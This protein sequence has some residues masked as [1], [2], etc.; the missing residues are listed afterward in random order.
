MRT[1]LQALFCFTFCFLYLSIS[2]IKA[3]DRTNCYRLTVE[4]IPDILDSINLHYGTFGLIS[5]HEIED[6]LQ[7]QLN[8]YPI[9]VEAV[10]AP[11]PDIMGFSSITIDF[12]WEHTNAPLLDF[13]RI[14]VLNLQESLEPLH[15]Q[16]TPDN[17][18]SVGIRPTLFE[19]LQLFSF[20]SISNAQ[21][22]QLHI[23]IID[24]DATIRC[25]NGG[26][27]E[28]GENIP[29]GPTGN[30]QRRRLSQN[31]SLQTIQTNLFPNP[32][33]G[34]LTNLQFELPRAGE[35][36]IQLYD[37]TNGQQLRQLMPPTF[38]EVGAHNLPIST[39]DLPAGYYTCMLQY[40]GQQYPQ[41]LV[42]VRP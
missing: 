22:S 16:P 38:Y 19:H 25:E 18:I 11:N 39:V 41:Q 36:S 17:F 29:L 28:E 37:L 7:Q 5:D 34:S 1:S 32:S 26:F 13:Y 14:S 24:K 6:F 33:D 15:L 35:V 30:E 12:H 42:V 27:V 8:Q 10:R 3:Q 21:Q 20:V 23:I 2:P 31:E 4:R 40:K 9:D